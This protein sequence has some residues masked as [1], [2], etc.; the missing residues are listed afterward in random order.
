MIPLHTDDIRPLRLSR[1]VPS[2]PATDPGWSNA[3]SHGAI[4]VRAESPADARLVAAEAEL[5]FTVIE[6]SDSLP[7]RSEGERGVIRGIVSVD[8][9]R[10]T[11]V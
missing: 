6:E 11:Q 7:P 1:L 10:P 4:V 3:P 2:A 5:D 9:I 8:T